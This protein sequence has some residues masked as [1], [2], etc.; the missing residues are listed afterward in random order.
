MKE[1]GFFLFSCF[2]DRQQ[3]KET[4]RGKSDILSFL[5]IRG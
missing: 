3:K 2:Y 4:T 1:A 5:S